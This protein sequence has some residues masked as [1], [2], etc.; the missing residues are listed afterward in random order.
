MKSRKRSSSPH[1]SDS[2]SSSSSSSETDYESSIR[3][4]SEKSA[5]S[6]PA[7]SAFAAGVRKAQWE[8]DIDAYLTP[9]VAPVNL[10]PFGAR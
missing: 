8:G 5:A 2:S 3:S 9:L 4:S 6:V 7:A 10:T 1:A